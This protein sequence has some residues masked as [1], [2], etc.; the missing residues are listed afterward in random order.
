MTYA[1]D[2]NAAADAE[3]RVGTAAKNLNTA[4][5]D[6]GGKVKQLASSWEGQEHDAYAGVQSKWD[7]AANEVTQILTE[8]QRI[9][10]DNSSDVAH[11]QKG[12]GTT[13]TGGA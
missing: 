3:D 9:V 11:M 4:L 8:I 5:Q 7:S 13:L 2:H 6:L 1:F 12:I 10:G